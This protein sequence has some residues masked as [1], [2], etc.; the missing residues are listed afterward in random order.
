VSVGMA[1]LVVS[2]SVLLLMGVP[3]AFVIGIATLLGALA[4]GKDGSFVTVA[5]DLANGLN[6]FPLL[7]WGVKRAVCRS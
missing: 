4:L 2:F 6:S 3:V 5:S 1:V 7:L